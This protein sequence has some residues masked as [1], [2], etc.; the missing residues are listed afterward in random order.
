[1]TFWI[2]VVALSLLLSATITG[3]IGTAVFSLILS[4]RRSRQQLD[5]DHSVRKI[6]FLDAAISIA[7]R[8]KP[9][10]CAGRSEVQFRD[11]LRG[12]KLWRG[13][14]GAVQIAGLLAA[15][16]AAVEEPDRASF[17]ANN[18]GH[19]RISVCPALAI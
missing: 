5:P 4:A 19:K 3:I 15:S 14:E 7:V 17:W 16:G 1:V 8:E 18:G 9:G 13:R 2:K 11:E 6:A 10:E 12:A